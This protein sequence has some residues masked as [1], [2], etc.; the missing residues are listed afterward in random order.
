MSPASVSVAPV[1]AAALAAVTTVT[2]FSV[3]DC[4]GLGDLA[5]ID[6]TAQATIGT[7][8][9]VTAAIKAAGYDGKQVVGYMLDG[10]SLTVVVK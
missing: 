5:A 3:D 7:N 4:S 9:A 1:D 2:V 10:T 6:P 8:A